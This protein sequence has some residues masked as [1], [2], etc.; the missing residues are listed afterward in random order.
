MPPIKS[1]LWMFSFVAL[2]LWNGTSAR[3]DR[4]E[5]IKLPPGFSI[6]V[7]APAPGARAI[8]I[9]SQMNMVFVGTR[10][11][12]VFAIPFVGGKAG[13][14]V[15]LKSGLKV[16]H[17]VVWHNGYLYIGEQHRIGRI[18][19]TSMEAL[20]RAKIETV[21][22][23]MT[24]SAWH[25]R[26]DLAVGPD[27]KLY[28]TL[29]TPCNICMPQ[30]NQGVIMRMDLD[31]ANP[32]VFANGIRNSVGLDFH[33]LTGDLYFTDNG[34]DRMGDD[35][36]P[37]EL[38]HAPVQGLH[39]GYPYFGGGTARTQDFQNDIPPANARQ[40][41]IQFGAHVAPL[42]L[43]FYRGT[44]FPAG[45]QNDAFVAHHGSWNR[46]IPDGYRI[47]RVRFD[48][49]GKALSW[50]PFAKGWLQGGKS[51]GRLSD[52]NELPDGSL[53]LSDDRQGV[54]YRISYSP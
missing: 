10:D 13:E 7:F 20:N 3:A 21:F 19:G 8:T 49:K 2:M 17:G 46:S 36:P 45:M 35:V 24:D 16:P 28:V 27:D 18:K 33:P 25:G 9:A 42:G 31:G 34:A 15:R 41:V 12:S 50:E 51:W 48:E 26:R 23:D 29:G 53:L 11:D 5:Q 38:N 30:R 22:D 1:L 37:E 43:H 14:T 4:L 47:A 44:Q 32:E 54:L 52:V 39:F 6:N 40:P